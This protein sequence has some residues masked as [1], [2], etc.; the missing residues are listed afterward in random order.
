MEIE[1]KTVKKNLEIK[2]VKN[3]ESAQLVKE[4]WAYCPKSE[5]KKQKKEEK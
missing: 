2:R 5:F 4:G 3:K 1:M